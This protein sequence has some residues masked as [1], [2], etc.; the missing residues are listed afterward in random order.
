[1]LNDTNDLPIYQ[2]QIKTLSELEELIKTLL[3][4]LNELPVYQQ[5]IKT[6]SK[7]QQQIKTYIRQLEVTDRHEVG[8]SSV[9]TPKDELELK[10]EYLTRTP[11]EQEKIVLAPYK[12]ES[13]PI[14]YE[15][16]QNLFPGAL[17]MPA[18]MQTTYEALGDYGFNNKNTMAMTTLCRD[19]ITKPFLIDIIRQWGKSF[20]CSSLAGFVMM[21]K[22]AF[23]AA[24]D[25]VPLMDNQRRFAYYA[26]PHIAISKDGEVGQVYRYGV[27]KVSHACGSL[28][29][30]AKELM[31]GR[32]K[33]EMDMQDLEQTII[34]QKILSSI[35]Y[36]DKP[37]LVEITKLA[38]QILAKEL[39]H[40]LSDVDT[41]LFKYAVMTGI[42]IHGPMD[43]TWI[44][45]Q[46]FYVVDRD[47]PSQ[48]EQ[49]N[50]FKA[51]QQHKFDEIKKQQESE[52]IKLWIL[53]QEGIFLG[54]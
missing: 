33:L 4:G 14:F 31:S 27:S 52:Q 18:Y 23:A 54:Q 10:S 6:L 26:M 20:N 35:N 24:A 32:L 49:L 13:N 53:N 50:S 2:Q 25:H 29:V 34:R 1:M 46:E 39:P 47:L 16:L 43:T 51:L 40:L 15:T 21:G 44:Y 42:Q 19:E 11:E 37:N 36:G 22:T 8:K 12:P 3:E 9:I 17:P 41:S 7:L 48:Q 28:E 5:Q 45:P 30:I 38:S